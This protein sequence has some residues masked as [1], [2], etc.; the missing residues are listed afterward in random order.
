V[1][2][3]RPGPT[4]KGDCLN[5]LWQALRR[6]EEG[7]ARRADA[8]I[9]HDAEDVVHQGELKVFDHL[10]RDYATVQLPVLP[11]VHRGSRM[12]SGHYCDEFAEP[13]LALAQLPGLA[14]HGH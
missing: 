13:N 1:I 4:T 8:V 5:N 11:L 7:G 14:K 9:L 12:I 3:D 2:G 6:D 10:I